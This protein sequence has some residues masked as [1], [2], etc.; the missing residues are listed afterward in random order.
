MADSPDRDTLRQQW[1]QHTDAVFER[2][3]PP[4]SPNTV[5]CFDHLEGRT[6]QLA[7][8][9]AVWLLEQRAQQAAAAAAAAPAC[10]HCGQPGQPAPP[11][12]DPRPK[13]TLVTRAGLLELHRDRYHCTTCRVVFFPP[14]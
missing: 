11:D 4:D 7:R 1:Q 14:G 9:L 3:F 10:P 12:D 2:L 8:D 6:L 5:P 13:R